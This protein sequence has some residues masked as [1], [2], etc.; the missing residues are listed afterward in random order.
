[1][2]DKNEKDNG[3]IDKNEKAEEDDDIIYQNN[4]DDAAPS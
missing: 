2:R 1:M 3:D 4:V